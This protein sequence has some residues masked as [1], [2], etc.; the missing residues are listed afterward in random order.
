ML[1]HAGMLTEKD[2][3]GTRI[4]AARYDETGK[5][6]FTQRQVAEWFE[7]QPQAV[8]EWEKDQGRPD[9]SK[10]G[11]L[12]TRTGKP[13]DYFLEVYGEIPSVS[14]ENV[15]ASIQDQKQRKRVPEISYVQAGRWKEVADPYSVGDARDWLSP[16]KDVSDSA[17]AL[18]IKGDSMEP[19]F[20]EGD[21]VIIDPAVRPRPGD[22]VVAKLHKQ[23]EATFKKYRLRGIDAQGD[24][25]ELVPE[26]GNHPTLRIDAD[27]PG[28]IV[29][30]MVEHRSYRRP[31]G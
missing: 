31:K 19:E 8:Y 22:Y 4:K 25:I 23:D 14:I 6:R 5:R 10:L 1:Y 20:H 15:V 26:N 16:D 7:I 29:G 2:T 17:F 18:E 11:T 27:N 9:I 21:K 30:T 12:A 24:I 13:L 3:L 28:E